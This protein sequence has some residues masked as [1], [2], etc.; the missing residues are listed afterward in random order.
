MGWPE[1]HE[2][3][4]IISGIT[5]VKYFWLMNFSNYIWL[6]SLIDLIVTQVTFAKH[7][8]VWLKKKTVLLNNI[9]NK[10][11][12]YFYDIPNIILEP[13]V[14]CKMCYKS[15]FDSK[16]EVSNCMDLIKPWQIVEAVENL[17]T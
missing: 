13:E 12:Y 15:N 11:E 3:N 17:L 4:K 10:Y 7:I 2:F 16:C 5:K 14:W 1:E 9:F 8:A 6:I